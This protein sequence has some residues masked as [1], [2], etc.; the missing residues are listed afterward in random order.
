MHNRLTND[1]FK[2]VHSITNYSLKLET[3]QMT[4]CNKMNKL[5][6]LSIIKYYAV[7]RMNKLQLNTTDDS[8]KHNI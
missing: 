2:N 1:M 3:F 7:M 5:W 8:L 4:I 6:Y